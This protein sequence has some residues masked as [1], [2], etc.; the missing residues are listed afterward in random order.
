MRTGRL[1]LILP[2]LGCAAL[3]AVTLVAA[4]VSS[5]GTTPGLQVPAT[6]VAMTGIAEGNPAGSEA[7]VP[8]LEPGSGDTDI[9]FE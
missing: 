1:R 8:N 4:L 5:G 2:A 7:L 6:L 9:D 3:I